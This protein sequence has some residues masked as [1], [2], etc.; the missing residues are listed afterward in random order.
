MSVA[1]EVGVDLVDDAER[2][3]GIG[4]DGGSDGHGARP[5]EQELDGVGAAG[6]AAHADDGDGHGLGGVVDEL[7]GDGF[8]RRAADAAG[9]VGQPRTARFDVDRHAGDCVD[10]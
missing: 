3:G 7:D 5:G 2:G 10:Q 6:D 1:L 4:E 8:D 9:H